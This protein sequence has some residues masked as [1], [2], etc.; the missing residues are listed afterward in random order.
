MTQKGLLRRKQTDQPTNQPK[1]LLQIWI[2]L[3][4]RILYN[5]FF[6]FFF[7]KK[8][9]IYIYGCIKKTPHIMTFRWRHQFWET[10]CFDFFFFCH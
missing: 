9:K 1:Y 6:F 5:I 3:E 4:D 2:I 8:K 7:L 10:R